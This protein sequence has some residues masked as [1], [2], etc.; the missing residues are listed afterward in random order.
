MTAAT[1]P[2]SRRPWSPRPDDRRGTG[3][4]YT[5]GHRDADEQFLVLTALQGN[6]GTVRSGLFTGYLVRDGLEAPLVDGA[7]RVVQRRDGF[8]LRIELDA[9]DALGRRLEAVGT[10]RNRFANQASPAQFA[11]MT[12]ITWRLPGAVELIGEDQEV[13][14]PDRL[15]PAL[16]ALATG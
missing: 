16:A 1:F 12:M 6:E 14:S 13:W 11:W 15:G 8:P 7:R 9:T 2:S 3:T 4:A 5:Y 10:A